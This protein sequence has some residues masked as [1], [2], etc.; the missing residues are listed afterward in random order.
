MTKEEIDGF[1]K[2]KE[3]R[4]SEKAAEI[5]RKEVEYMEEVCLATPYARKLHSREAIQPADFLD[6]CVS[7]CSCSF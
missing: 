5:A 7:C 2:R 6:R 4:I 3:E 1:I